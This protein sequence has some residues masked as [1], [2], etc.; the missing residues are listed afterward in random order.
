MKKRDKI[1]YWVATGLASLLLIMGVGMYFFNHDEVA[2]MFTGMG[3]PE[4]LIYPLG[5]AKLLGIIAIT[6]RKSEMLKEW[7]YAGFVFELLL[8]VGAHISA[9][10]GEFGGAVAVL[11]LILVS[12]V[13]SKRAFPKAA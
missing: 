2:K 10:D 6:T 7:A 12:Y 13:F 4:Y 8:G 11:I 9:G 5:V 3:Y 1:I